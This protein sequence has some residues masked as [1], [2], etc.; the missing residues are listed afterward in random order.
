M[1]RSSAQKRKPE[2]WCPEGSA[3]DTSIPAFLFLVKTGFGAFSVLV[4]R[5]SPGVRLIACMTCL[6][7]SRF[8]G[9]GAEARFSANSV[10]PLNR[11]REF[12]G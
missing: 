10:E 2:G 9:L 3:L 11:N 4:L 8:C 5:L 12:G 7:P 1:R 6:R